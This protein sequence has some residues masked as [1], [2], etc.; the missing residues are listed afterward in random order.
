VARALAAS[1]ARRDHAGGLEPV[2]AIEVLEQ[3]GV[4]MMDDWLAGQGE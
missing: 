1:A 2:S 4:Q 3:R